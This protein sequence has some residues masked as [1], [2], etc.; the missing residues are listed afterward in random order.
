MVEEKHHESSGMSSYGRFGILLIVISALVAAEAFAELGFVYKLWPVLIFLLGIGFIGIYI[1]RARREAEYIGVGTY[2]VC[3]SGL[4]LYC[5]FT[6]WTALSYLWPLF[7]GFFGFSFLMG[8]LFGKRAPLALLLG[9]L[10]V[11][12]CV[13][14]FF[15]FGLEGQYWW[16]MFL[17]A[18]A[19]FFIYDRV[20][21]T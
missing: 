13:V 3:F 17:L 2:L 9:L 1:R 14:F 5:S 18:G 8:Y 20:R 11:S 15:V 19:S 10:L 6:S 4:A 12:I 21:S 16:T 7:I